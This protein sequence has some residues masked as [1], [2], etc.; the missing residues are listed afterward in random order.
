M[1]NL[2]SDAEYFNIEQASLEELPCSN[3]TVIAHASGQ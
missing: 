2:Q 1:K 3:V